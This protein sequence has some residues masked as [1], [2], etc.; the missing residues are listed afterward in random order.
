[1]DNISWTTLTFLSK[2]TQ[3]EL[4]SVKHSDDPQVEYFL[5]MCLA[6]E[7]I[8]SNNHLTVHGLDILVSKNIISSTRKNEILNS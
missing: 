4:L 3:D 7:R 6:A 1:M 2:F 5:L 8:V